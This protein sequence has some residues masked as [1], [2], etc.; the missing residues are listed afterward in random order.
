MGNVRE[1]QGRR[2]RKRDGEVGNGRH[3][4]W[5]HEICEMWIRPDMPPRSTKAPYG[6]TAVTT[7]LRTVP[8]VRSEIWLSALA[9]RYE[10]TRREFS[11]STSR[12]LTFSFL[13]MNSSLGV[14]PA[15]KWLPGRK[16]RR[17][18]TS[19]IAPP[20]LTATTSP[21]TTAS[22][23]YNFATDSHAVSKSSRRRES[24]SW[25]FS[26][27]RDTMTNS[28]SAPSARQFSGLSGLTSA[29]SCSV[30]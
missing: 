13:P 16:A 6:L 29:I 21:S 23:A 11:L 25:P 9:F 18:S 2:G 14:W 5:S 26:S 3:A 12:N 19:I 24:M 1:A 28:Y 8:T 20:R 27:S 10:T 17:P 22:S 7:P 4:L 30:T 15:M